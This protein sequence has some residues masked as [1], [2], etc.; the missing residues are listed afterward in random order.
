MATFRMHP[1]A[2]E[3]ILSSP[4]M[5]RMLEERAERVR[6]RAEQIAPVRTGRY[7][8]GMRI[9]S[10]GKGGGFEIE[11]GVERGRAYARVINRTPYA[12]YLEFG[13][14]YMRKQRILGNALDM[15]FHR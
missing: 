9:P 8:F 2:L 13:T 14:R 1:G 3:R 12:I 10:G 5:Q 7:A 6:I 4:A 11:T 15:A